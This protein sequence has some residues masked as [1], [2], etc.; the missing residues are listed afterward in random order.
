MLQTRSPRLSVSLIV[1]LVIIL[2]LQPT[3]YSLIRPRLFFGPNVDTTTRTYWWLATGW[4]LLWVWLPFG[5]LCWVVHHGGYKWQDVAGVDWHFFSR[6]RIV[7]AVLLTL[8]VIGA[9]IAPR[10]LYHGNT[11]RISPISIFRPVSC[12]ERVMFLVVAVSA[13]ICE[14]VTYRGLPLRLLASS[15]GRAWTVLPVTMVAFVFHHGPLSPMVFDYL[16]LGF[17]FGSIFILLGRRRLEW[18]IILHVVYDAMFA[19]M[20]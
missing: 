9:V 20:P 4:V 17:L 8:L 5:I 15:S 18:L 6:H 13:G 2:V 1:V 19:F 11:P 3:L 7:C 16:F 14:E 12:A 10:L